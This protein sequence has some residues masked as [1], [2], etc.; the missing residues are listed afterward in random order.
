MPEPSSEVWQEDY[1]TEFEYDQD[2]NTILIIF[3]EWDWAI[4]D[5]LPDTRQEQIYDSEG[6]DVN[7]IFLTSQ[8][9][10]QNLLI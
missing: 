3:S 6:N 2:G 9:L 5:W 10:H 7:S 8:A 4:D 1:K